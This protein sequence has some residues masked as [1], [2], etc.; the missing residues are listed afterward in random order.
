MLNIGKKNGKA[1][2]CA[3][4]THNYESNDLI[5][6]CSGAGKL[7]ER[8]NVTQVMADDTG[9][10]GQSELETCMGRRS[11]KLHPISSKR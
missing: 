1:V 7:E 9:I 4:N 8:E 3:V 5:D 6:I 10:V 11:R 2:E